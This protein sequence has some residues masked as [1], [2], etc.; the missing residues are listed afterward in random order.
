[1][2]ANSVVEVEEQL[3]HKFPDLSALLCRIN[4]VNVKQSNP[5]LERLKEEITKD[6][7]KR[8]SIGSVKGTSIFRA[9]RD[10]FWIR[11][12]E[13]SLEATS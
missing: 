2:R 7:Y 10:F 4:D 1:M 12:L 8:Y 13:H 11:R 3:K 5:D 9:Y 6:V